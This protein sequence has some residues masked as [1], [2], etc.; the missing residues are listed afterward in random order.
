MTES[1]EDTL[2]ASLVLAATEYCEAFLGRDVRP[3]SYQLLCDGFPGEDYLRIEMPG[4]GAVSEVARMV[5][6]TFTAFAESTNWYLSKRTYYTD[7]VLETGI[8]WPTD[9]DDRRDNVRVTFATVAPERVDL[10]RQGILKHVAAMYADRGDDEPMRA[11]QG[12]FRFAKTLAA[13]T[14]AASGAEGFYGP[15]A[16]VDI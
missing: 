15:L 14:A 4:V 13:N 8:S 9:A 10:A 1:S 7:V 12:G 6:G 16:L 3:N 11:E 2:I 5:S